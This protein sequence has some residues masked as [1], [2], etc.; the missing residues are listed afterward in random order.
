MLLYQEILSRL[1]S[2]PLIITTDGSQGDLPKTADLA[3]NLPATPLSEDSNYA[4]DTLFELYD[5]YIENRAKSPR[6]WQLRTRWLTTVDD[7]RLIGPA[8]PP[9]NAY[10]EFRDGN[11]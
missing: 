11:R 9:T 4:L 8:P 7:N 2:L 3:V 5:P 6:L 1:R 10:K